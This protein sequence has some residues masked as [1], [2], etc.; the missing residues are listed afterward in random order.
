MSERRNADAIVRACL[1]EVMKHGIKLESAY[2]FASHA[3][4][5]AHPDSDINLSLIG[6]THRPESSSWDH[7]KWHGA[8][9]IMPRCIPWT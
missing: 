3:R 4:G 1:A 8:V 6:N 2:L 5:N 9:R 7:L